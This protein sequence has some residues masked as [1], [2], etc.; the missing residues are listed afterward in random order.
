MKRERARKKQKKN[1]WIG[2]IDDHQ[3]AHIFNVSAH[4]SIP[5]TKTMKI[6]RKTKKDTLNINDKSR[7]VWLLEGN[8]IIIWIDNLFFLSHSLVYSFSI[9]IHLFLL[10]I[11]MWC[12]KY[13]IF[14]VH[15]TSVDIVMEKKI[16]TANVCCSFEFYLPI[17]QVCNLMKTL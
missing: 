15:H 7:Y 5:F 3:T 11:I 16:T 9:L 2:S 4:Q 8:R 14:L 1:E 10:K 12:W 13:L 6:Y 17:I